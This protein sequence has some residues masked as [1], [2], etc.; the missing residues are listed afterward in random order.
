MNNLKRFKWLSVLIIACFILEQPVLPYSY[1]KPRK[2]SGADAFGMLAGSLILYKTPI[3]GQ[4]LMKAGLNYLATTQSPKVFKSFGLNQSWQNIGGSALAGGLIGGMNS[5]SMGNNT[6]IKNILKDS[7]H[8]MNPYNWQ[9]NA[10]L[11][12]AAKWATA[13]AI[14]HYGYKKNWDDKVFG[15]ATLLASKIGA[16]AVETG[17][18]NY[19]NLGGWV[20][21]KKGEFSNNIK[22]A[23]NLDYRVHKVS[24]KKDQYN[25]YSADSKFKALALEGVSLASAGLAERYLGLEKTPEF[26][27]TVGTAMADITR[28][29]GSDSFAK[30]ATRALGTAALSGVTNLALQQ[31]SQE[32][33]NLGPYAGSITNLMLTS[34]IRSAVSGHGYE[35]GKQM[36]FAGATQ[37]AGSLLSGGI[38]TLD[39][40]GNIYYN[41]TPDASYAAEMIDF[42]RMANKQTSSAGKYDGS[43]GGGLVNTI[44]N[45]YFNNLNSQANANIIGMMDDKLDKIQ[46]KKQADGKYVRQRDV[47]TIEGNMIT[48]QAPLWNPS[49][50]TEVQLPKEAPKELKTTENIKDLRIASAD[51]SF[52]PED[53]QNALASQMDALKAVESSKPVLKENTFSK[54]LPETISSLVQGTTNSV[55]PT[56]IRKNEAFVKVDGQE[57]KVP[58]E[59][60]GEFGIGRDSK[61]QLR[62]AGGVMMRPVVVKEN[63][64]GNAPAVL[65][66]GR[67]RI[68][69][70]NDLASQQEVTEVITNIA[71]MPENAPFL[72]EEGKSYDAKVAGTDEKVRVKVKSVTENPNTYDKTFEVIKE[73]GEVETVI[74]PYTNMKDAFE[75]PQSKKPAKS[76]SVKPAVENSVK[77]P[78]DS[79]PSSEPQGYIYDSETETYLPLVPELKEPGWVRAEDPFKE[80]PEALRRAGGNID[81]E[82]TND[83]E[84]DV[85]DKGI[86][87]LP[88]KAGEK[89]TNLTLEPANSFRNVK[90][91]ENKYYNLSVKDYQEGKETIIPVKV[92]SNEIDD[93]DRRTVIVELPNGDILPITVSDNE[94]GKNGLNANRFGPVKKYLKESQ[95]IQYNR[96]QSESTKS[97]VTENSSVDFIWPILDEKIIKDVMKGLKFT[98]AIEPVVTSSRTLVPA[99]SDSKSQHEFVESIITGN[100]IISPEEAV[101][102]KYPEKHISCGENVVLVVNAVIDSAKNQ[103]LITPEMEVS[104]KLELVN[105]EYGPACQEIVTAFQTANGLMPDKSIGKDTISILFD[106]KSPKPPQSRSIVPAKKSTAL[107]SS[108][109]VVNN[110]PSS[111]ILKYANKPLGELKKIMPDLPTNLYGDIKQ[112]LRVPGKDITV[113][114]ADTHLGGNNVQIFTLNKTGKVISSC[115]V[116]EV[117]MYVDWAGWSSEN[118]SIKIIDKKIG[119]QADTYAMPTLKVDLTTGNI[120]RETEKTVEI[121]SLNTNIGNKA[122][123]YIGS[124]PFSPLNGSKGIE[125]RVNSAT[126]NRNNKNVKEIWK[127]REPI[128]NS[129]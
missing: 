96:A 19:G 108:S 88:R 117:R 33:G 7:M 54:V 84:F 111:E 36:F 13:G 29:V 48:E 16:T 68:P 49:S 27:R 15:G 59:R 23:N 64:A 94:D 32:M 39:P 11:M 51:N 25:P 101:N 98:P 85:A 105:Q 80:M 87:K 124:N 116:D 110:T 17:L 121:N 12:D 83:Y 38:G 93:F 118:P 120:G 102:R 43:H 113:V 78:G 63:K 97:V 2:S 73:N 100:T 76:E 9:K 24:F 91:D 5:V 42:S 58:E 65:P 37:A 81:F 53:I 90:P 6:G 123:G 86:G 103:K 129:N 71:P 21:E 44:V 74:V 14:Q 107:S 92:K 125:A 4:S 10:V 20:I 115:R 109:S 3:S 47:K 99:K 72:F 82:Q 126:T 114:K 18:S 106:V 35:L 89:I 31:V 30:G 128:K 45:K 75:L 55:L 40:K 122:V 60:L 61:G 127:Y 22:W 56:E 46:Y 112:I 66:E 69:G 57:Y 95:N 52:M 77:I 28:S 119:M 34:G 67:R 104:A 41:A 79:L 1:A 8:R 70:V 26:S 50:F 62:K